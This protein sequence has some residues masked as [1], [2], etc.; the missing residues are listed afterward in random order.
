MDSLH[1][2]FSAPVVSFR[3]PFFPGIQRG[4]PV[5]P[6]STVRGLLA[7]AVGGFE[8]LGSPRVGIAFAASGV[9]RD[10]ET[11][12]PLNIDGKARFAGAEG[13][14]TPKAREF[15]VDVALDLWIIDSDLDAWRQAMRRPVWPIRLGRTQDLVSLVE[16]RACKLYDG[17]GRQHHALLP[18]DRL[19]DA[20]RA[21]ARG[22][23]YRLATAVSVDRYRTTYGEYVWSDCPAEAAEGISVVDGW[24]DASGQLVCPLDLGL[25]AA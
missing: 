25:A 6:P 19:D 11:F 7:A 15:L 9:G 24:H 17:P 16:A 5:V 10:D 14:P 23:V 18:L 13:G 12:H 3:D 22:D 21:A 4:L 20:N 8:R 2:A 1:V